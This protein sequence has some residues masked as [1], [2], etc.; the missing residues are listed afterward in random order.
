[1]ELPTLNVAELERLAIAQALRATDGH[2]GDAAELLGIGR[3]TLY[4]RLAEQETWPSR[5]P[6]YRP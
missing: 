6:G 4:R 3:A 2:V 1:M 5:R